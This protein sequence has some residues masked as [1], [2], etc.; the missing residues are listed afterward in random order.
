MTLEYQVPRVLWENLEA[1]LL[2][3][4]KRYIGELAGILRVPEKDLLRRVL[5]AHD[6]LKV[7]IQDSHCDSHQCKAYVQQD[8]LTVFCKK[9]VAYQSDFCPF[10]R[11]KRMTVIGGT[12]PVPIQR[13][14]DHPSRPPLWVQGETLIHSNGDQVGTID[15]EQ[16][17]MTLFIIE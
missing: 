1:V 5:P 13:V 7:I 12:D 10:H 14:K 15:V 17:K 2:A 6:S 11:N 9:P 4:S 8:K 16:Q 3:Q